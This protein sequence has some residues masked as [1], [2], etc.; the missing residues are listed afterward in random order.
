MFHNNL[1]F[2]SLHHVHMY[3]N[4]V[5]ESMIIRILNIVENQ[6]FKLFINV[7][8][9]IIPR[10]HLHLRCFCFLISTGV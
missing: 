4:I 1:I 6:D 9:E 8:Q 5:L 7:A 2:H 3:I 10:A